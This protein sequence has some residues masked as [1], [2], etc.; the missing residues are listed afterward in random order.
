M[1]Q[2]VLV[3]PQNPGHVGIQVHS[4][5]NNLATRSPANAPIHSIREDAHPP[6]AS[7]TSGNAG[8]TKH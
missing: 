5:T 4:F 2:R 6:Y 8:Q 7:V 1:P 3:S